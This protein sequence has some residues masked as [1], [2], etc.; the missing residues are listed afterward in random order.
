MEKITHYVNFYGKMSM[1]AGVAYDND[2][3][4]VRD[5]NEEIISA[6]SPTHILVVLL[7]CPE[8][9]GADRHNCKKP[10]TLSFILPV[11][12][13]DFNCLM[14]DD[15]LFQNTARVRD[16]EIL[17]GTQFFRNRSIW[18]FSEA[19]ALRTR[20]SQELWL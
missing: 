8:E 1:Y 7:R 4:S 12:D 17:S 5:N 18:S 3:D 19:I 14:S 6:R 15:Y 10:L 11:I 2:G 16:I 20:V 13:E 9:K